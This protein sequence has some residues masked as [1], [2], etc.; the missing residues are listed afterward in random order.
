MEWALKDILDKYK[1][2]DLLRLVM[3]EGHH[4]TLYFICLHYVEEQLHRVHIIQI[5]T[6]EMLLC[7]GKKP[8]IL[9][10]FEKT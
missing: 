2:V 6:G 9:D 5:E 10:E 4:Q 3:F 7:R 8:Q 1:K